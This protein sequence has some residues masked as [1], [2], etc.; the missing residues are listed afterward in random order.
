[1]VKAH[2]PNVMTYFTHHI[3]SATN[4]AINGVIKTL[5]KRSYGFRSFPN[6]RTAVLFHCGKLQLYPAT[7]S[8]SHA[9]R[10]R[11]PLGPA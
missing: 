11:L 4:E 6:F 1:M 10:A 8:C 5:I 7:C 3:T 2:L 9:R